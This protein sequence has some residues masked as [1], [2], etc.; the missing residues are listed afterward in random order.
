MENGSMNGVAKVDLPTANERE[1]N[2]APALAVPDN[3]LVFTTLD[4]VVATGIWPSPPCDLTLERFSI[5]FPTGDIV[6][7]AYDREF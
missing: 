5:S 2:T 6:S 3:S 4:K 1:E 7:L